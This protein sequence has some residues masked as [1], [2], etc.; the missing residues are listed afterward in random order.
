MKAGYMRDL[1]DKAI[2]TLVRYHQDATSPAS[3]IHVHHFGGAVAR[4]DD[5]ETAYG[6]RQAPYVLNII[7]MSHEE[8]GLD[9]HVDWAQRL[10]GEIEP[11][12]TGGAY[13]NFLSAEGK[14]RVQAAYGAEKFARLRA[15]KDRYD[16]TNL[17]HLNQNVPPTI[18]PP[19]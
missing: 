13:I 11:S 10:Y 15:L 8:G 16:P 9:S 7:A 5:D 4:V 17:F 19:Q 14:E 12:L 2:E 6:D 18:A 1:D 3:E